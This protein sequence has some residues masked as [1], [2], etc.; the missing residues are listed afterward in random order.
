MFTFEVD[1]GSQKLDDLFALLLEDV[2]Q[3]RC[4]ETDFL[5][6]FFGSGVF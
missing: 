2:R 3:L 5:R 4:P 1:V 6:A